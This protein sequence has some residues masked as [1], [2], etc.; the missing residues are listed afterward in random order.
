MTWWL[1][2]S[3]GGG[4]LFL[5]SLTLNW[6]CD[7]LWPTE[8]KRGDIMPGLQRLCLL[9]CSFGTLWSHQVNKPST[10]CR[11]IQKQSWI[12]GT[13]GNTAEISRSVGSQEKVNGFYFKTLS[14]GLLCYT[15]TVPFLFSG[16]LKGQVPPY[17]LVATLNRDLGQRFLTGTLQ[18]Y[19]ICFNNGQNFFLW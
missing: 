13:W 11:Q 9:A 14:L 8:C 3:R 7:L 1:F 15:I 18:V 4:S 16:R 17:S 10:P 5:L 19:F 6:P 12:S 2:P